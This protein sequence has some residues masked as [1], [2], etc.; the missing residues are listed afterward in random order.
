MSLGGTE[1][2]ICDPATTVHPGFPERDRREFGITSALIRKSIAIEGARAR[3][4]RSRG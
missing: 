1:T 4:C 2:L 3:R